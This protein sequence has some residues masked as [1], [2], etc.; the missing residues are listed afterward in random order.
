MGNGPI[1]RPA[2]SSIALL[3]LLAREPCSLCLYLSTELFQE[4]KR[5]TEVSLHA[6]IIY[7]VF[8]SKYIYY[9]SLPM[10][11]ATYIA[12]RDGRR[13]ATRERKC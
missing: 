4:G 8:R 7:V 1:T 10:F 11:S 12:E 13:L 2:R 3:C 6:D 5:Q 9:P